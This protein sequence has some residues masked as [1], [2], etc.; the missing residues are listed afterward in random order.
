MPEPTPISALAAVRQDGPCT[1]T[2]AEPDARRD[3]EHDKGSKGRHRGDEAAGEDRPGHVP[4]RTE[5]EHARGYGDDRPPR[6]ATPAHPPGNGGVKHT[7][8]HEVT[9]ERPSGRRQPGHQVTCPP[10]TGRHRDKLSSF[11]TPVPRAHP[12]GR[13]GDEGPEVDQEM[14]LADGGGDLG[15]PQGRLAETG[16]IGGEPEDQGD[17]R[18]QPRH[19]VSTQ[20]DPQQTPWQRASASESWRERHHLSHGEGQDREPASTAL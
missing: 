17:D 13:A 15:T 19:H 18:Q 8:E 6:W 16:V 20:L 12:G 2:V 9:G 11:A 4:G 10:G 1:D 5:Q 7:D 3:Q 14:A